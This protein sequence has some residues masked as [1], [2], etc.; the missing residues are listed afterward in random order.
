M[1]AGG[2]EVGADAFVCSAGGDVGAFR[3]AEHDADLGAGLG[4]F[5]DE[6]EDA[7]VLGEEEAA[8]DEDVDVVVG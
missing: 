1:D 2:H 8:V 3:V 5:G 4:S 7:G 6:L